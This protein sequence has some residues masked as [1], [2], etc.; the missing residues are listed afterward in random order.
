M[1]HLL[2]EGLILGS[3]MWWL[4]SHLRRARYPP[5][6]RPLPLIGNA[7]DIPRSCPWETIKAWRETFGITSSML[8]L[9][10]KL[11]TILLRRGF[12]ICQDFQG[13]YPLHQLV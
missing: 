1:V 2:V 8:R 6:P 5:G 4:S 10:N 12:N 3:V 7:L 13:S 11:L 9:Q